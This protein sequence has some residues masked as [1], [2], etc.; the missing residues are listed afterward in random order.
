M[1][2]H[3]SVSGNWGTSDKARRPVAM[4]L[5]PGKSVPSHHGDCDMCGLL[6]S[7][8]GQSANTYAGYKE[9]YCTFSGIMPKRAAT[10]A[11]SASVHLS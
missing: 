4:G 2:S 9:A 10:A 7:C 1:S 11:I 6:T 3:V 8:D 5:P